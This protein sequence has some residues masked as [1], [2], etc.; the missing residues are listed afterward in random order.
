MNP[1]YS[2]KYYIIWSTLHLLDLIY[3]CHVNMYLFVRMFTSLIGE[4]Q[5]DWNSSCFVSHHLPV[6]SIY[7]FPA[8][9]RAKDNKSGNVYLA[10]ITN[11]WLKNTY[12]TNINHYVVR[13][14]H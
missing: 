9:Q 11:H 14:L 12:I 1:N 13:N 10:W 7:W 3:V 2:K 4:Y 6:F 5:V 8:Q